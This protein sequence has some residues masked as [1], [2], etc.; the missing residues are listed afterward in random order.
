[1]GGDILDTLHKKNKTIAYYTRCI[2]DLILSNW[3]SS[4]NLRK[5]KQT[6]KQTNKNKNKKTKKSNKKQP[7]Q[8]K[9]KQK[10][11]Q[12]LRKT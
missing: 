11:Q 5:K 12:T 4:K 1:M 3:P 7:K 9:N 6:N 2:Y 8:S 10:N